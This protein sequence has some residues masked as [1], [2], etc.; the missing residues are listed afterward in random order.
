MSTRHDR[1]SV[2][3]EVL[4]LVEEPAVAPLLLGDY[5][6]A[7]ALTA[8]AWYPALVAE[9]RRGEQA[10][11]RAGY[12]AAEREMAARWSTMA[13]GVRAVLKAPTLAERYARAAALASCP[14]ECGSCSSC[15]RLAA[16]A[17][18]RRRYGVDDFPGC[19]VVELDGAGERRDH[20]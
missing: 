10:G 2:E 6:E 13:A 18:N 19:G 14:R 7:A 16:I 20:A 11:F 15:I 9:Y 5:I 17:A 12:A 8:E 4:T 3:A 1:P